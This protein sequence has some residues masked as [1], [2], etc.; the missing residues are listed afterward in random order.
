MT[1]TGP[2]RSLGDS[3]LRVRPEKTQLYCKRNIYK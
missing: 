3:E 2:L 1:R